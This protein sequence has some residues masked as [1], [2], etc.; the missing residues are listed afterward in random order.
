MSCSRECCHR[1]VLSYRHSPL[2][3]LLLLPSCHAV[4]TILLAFVVAAIV[5]VTIPVPTVPVARSVTV[6]VSTATADTV[7]LPLFLVQL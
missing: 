4:V 3:T 1:I 2:V 6:A 5:T 7:V